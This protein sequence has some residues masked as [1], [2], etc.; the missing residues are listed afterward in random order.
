MFTIARDTKDALIVTNCGAEAISFLKVYGVIPAATG[1]MVMYSRLSDRFSSRDLFYVTM[2]PFVLFYAL[3]AFVLYP[4]RTILHP[5]SLVVPEGGAGYAINLLRHWTFSLYYIVS[6]LWGSAGV[7][8]LFWTCANDVVRVDEARR[9]YPLISLIG[10]LG[11]IFS[12]LAM[13]TVSAV[14][15]AKVNSDEL[16][17]EASL[18]ILNMCSTTAGC[19]VMALHWYVYSIQR[20]DNKEPILTTPQ[21]TKV[22]KIKPKLS[23]ADSLRLLSADRYLRS[24]ATMVVSY[25]LSIEFTEI[26][27]KAAVKKAFPSKTEYLG[28]MGRYSLLVGCSSF[29]MTVVGSGVIKQLGW[30]AGALMVTPPP[31]PNPPLP[32]SSFPSLNPSHPPINLPPKSRRRRW[33]WEGS[34]CPSSPAYAWAA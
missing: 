16:A 19:I 9:L 28:F 20:S 29:V 2:S 3:F 18:K 4:A 17:F 27:W 5:M 10:N 24:I 7:P 15:R 23:F 13:Q 6:E 8:L 31:L 32:F 26:I 34:V 30:R 11:P 21:E 25:G 22:K 14:V 33:S 1:F 12:G